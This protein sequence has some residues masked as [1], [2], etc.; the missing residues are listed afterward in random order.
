MEKKFNKDSWQWKFFQEYWKFVQKYYIP[1]ATDEWWE[2]V[3]AKADELYKKY[4]D[5]FA[6]KMV[7]TFLEDIDSRSTNGKKD[8]NELERSGN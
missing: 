3:I 5:D 2:D 4:P 8:K 6:K 1:E 7:R